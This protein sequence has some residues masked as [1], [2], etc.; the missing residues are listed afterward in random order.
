M[1]NPLKSPQCSRVA[2]SLYHVHLLRYGGSLPS[3]SA[4]VSLRTTSKRATPRPTTTT[5][6][7]SRLLPVNLFPP[8]IRVYASSHDAP[9]VPGNIYAEGYHVRPSLSPL[10]GLPHTVRHVPDQPTF[11]FGVGHIPTEDRAPIP[12]GSKGFN[13]ALAE[14]VTGPMK[15]FEIQYVPDSPDTILRVTI[16]HITLGL[17]PRAIGQGTGTTN[18]PSAAPSTPQR[19]KYVTAASPIQPASEPVASSSKQQQMISTDSPTKSPPKRGILK[20][21][22]YTVNTEDDGEEADVVEPEELEPEDEELGRGKRKGKKCA[23]MLRTTH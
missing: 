21:V 22:K 20:H 2:P 16:D 15:Q 17:A 9:P 5:T 18:G 8:K 6:P 1:C 14:Y 4:P 11:I 7:R 13:I 19:R 12:S 23:R 10:L 3:P